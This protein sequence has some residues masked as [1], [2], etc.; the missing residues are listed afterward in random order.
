MIT[1]LNFQGTYSPVFFLRL[2]APFSLLRKFTI[3]R[4]LYFCFPKEKFSLVQISNNSNISSIEIRFPFSSPPRVLLLYEY[5]VYEKVIKF[6]V[7]S[8]AGSIRF[9]FSAFFF[10]TRNGKNVKI[11]IVIRLF[12]Q[13]E[14][15]STKIHYWYT[16]SYSG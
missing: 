5:R 3:S 4:K 7:T 10:F 9:H 13:T 8:H 15:I 6:L 12:L 16:Y 1:R 11:N 2:K 14:H